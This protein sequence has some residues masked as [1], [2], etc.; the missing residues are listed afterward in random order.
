MRPRLGGVFYFC[1]VK[2]IPT[3]IFHRLLYLV[4]L[5]LSFQ[6]H[7]QYYSLGSDPSAIKWNHAKINHFDLI[8]PENEAKLA[9]RFGGIINDLAVPVTA[10]MQSNI[11]NLPVIMH[12]YS[13]LSNGLSVLAPRRIELFPKQPIALE[14]SDFISQLAI[15]EV[16]HFAQMD[17]LNTGVTR[18]LGYILGEQ[19]QAV[20]LGIFVPRWLLEGDAVLAETLLSSAG[21]GRLASFIQP[22][23]SR[24]VDNKDLSWD[25]VLFGSYKEIL[26]N[27]YLFGY[28]FAARGRMLADPMVW[29]DAIGEIGRNPF[30]PKGLS[31]LTRPKTGFGFSS[32]YQETMDWLRDF[33]TDPALAVKT[34]DSLYSIS[35]DLPEFQ[36]YYRPQKFS[37]HEVICLKWTLGDLP[38]FVI[39]DSSANERILTRPGTIENAGF[40]YFEGKLVWTEIIQDPRWEERSWSDLFSYDVKTDKKT[41]LS[42]RQRYFSPVFS[43]AGDNIALIEERA[44]GASFVQLIDPKDCKALNSMPGARDDHF[45]HLCWGKSPDELFAVTTGPQGRKLIRIDFKQMQQEVLLDAGFIDIS[46]PAVFHDWIYFSGPAGATQGLYRLNLKTRKTEFVFGHPHGIN[47]LTTQGQD[48]FLSVYSSNGY[49][50]AKVSFASMHGKKI[51]SIKPLIEPV[52]EVIERAKGEFPV[53]WSDSVQTPV[54]KP[55]RKFTHLLRLHSWSPVFLNPDAY[56]ISPGVVLMSQNDLSTLTCWGGYQYI[57]TDL[58]HNL[59]ASV[60]YTG[61]YPTLEVDYNRKY[62]SPDPESDSKDSQPAK[63]PVAFQQNLR[64]GSGIPLTFTS[65]AWSRKIKPTVFF[66]QISYLQDRNSDLNQ[67]VWMAGFSISYSFLRKMSYRDLFPKWG[68]SMNFSYYK[69]FCKTPHLENNFIA[70]IITYMPGILPN[71]S[72]RILNSIRQLNFYELDSSISDFPRGQIVSYWG[73]SYNLK[74]D[75]AFPVAYPDYHLTWLIYINRIKADLFFDAGT[76]TYNIN[77][78][79]STGLD[80]TFNYHLLRVGVPLESGIRMMYF[81]VFRKIGAEFLFSFS[82][83]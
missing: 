67:S 7:A 81:P 62:R 69:A 6:A 61:L 26:P 9:S 19:A 46:C 2:R 57:K 25:R 76:S 45:S 18:A 33:W 12:P 8:Y 5:L 41:R 15:H 70:R 66:E 37:N 71:S 3:T 40:S 27:E 17:R 16:R 72:L 1:S 78:F 58:S 29:S 36:N 39:I 32:L 13:V 59:I 28:F 10:S 83:N 64:I 49:R 75:Y 43:P 73:Q 24:L 50:P 52:T 23:R 54:I 55:Y 14:T 82:V 20:V 38:A 30:N 68:A 11:R 48:L 53:V 22:L 51:N 34:P 63:F 42:H 35:A 60:R 4:F 21:R 74:I 79:L 31:G 80:L 56:Q 77:W 47:F 65:G 44:D